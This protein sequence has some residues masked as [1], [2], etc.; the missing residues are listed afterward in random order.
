[1]LDEFPEDRIETAILYA[2]S[3]YSVIETK[4]IMKAEG[5]LS[6]DAM[7]K[8]IIKIAL[9]CGVIFRNKE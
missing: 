2:D 1:M 7:Y 8:K 6:E 4:A 5:P 9:E 3:Y